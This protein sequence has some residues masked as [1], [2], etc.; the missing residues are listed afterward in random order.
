M[1]LKSCLSRF[2]S[3]QRLFYLLTFYSILCCLT[4]LY[5]IKSIY[6]LKKTKNTK[7]KFY[8][9]LSREHPLGRGSHGGLP[10]HPTS[11]LSALCGLQLRVNQEELSEK[12]SGTPG[13]EQEEGPGTDRH[14]HPESKQQMRANVIQEIMNTER[15]YIKHLKDIC[16]VR[17]RSRGLVVA[18]A[19]RARCPCAGP[20]CPLRPGPC[21]LLARGRS[22][23][24]RAREATC[25]AGTAS[26]FSGRRAMVAFRTPL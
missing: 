9:H 23:P 6:H 2:F 13:G 26:P 8:A 16:E 10:P 12:S 7:T 4:C 25:P 24:W 5:I 15:V 19:C 20:P 11:H 18:A 3:L 21:R 14:R 17:P 1:R 22:P